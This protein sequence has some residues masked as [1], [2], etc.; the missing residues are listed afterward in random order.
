MA[1]MGIAVTA[2][3]FYAL[4]SMRQV[5]DIT[6]RFFTQRFVEA[7]LAT[8]GIILGLGMKQRGIADQTVIYAVTLV[9]Q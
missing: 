3:N 5:F 6:N 1:Q 2:T 9:M 8:A 7:G 4:H